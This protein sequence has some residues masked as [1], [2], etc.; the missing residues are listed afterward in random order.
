M[1]HDTDENRRL[2]RKLAKKAI[3]RL[4]GT[5]KKKRRCRLPGVD[6]VLKGVPVK[7][8]TKN[9]ENCEWFDFTFLN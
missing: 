3:A 8:K 2:Q 1:L 4:R 5:G 7:E 6:S 9:D